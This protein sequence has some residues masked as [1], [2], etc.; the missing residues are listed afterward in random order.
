MRLLDLCRGTLDTGH[1]SIGW[2]WVG[3]LVSAVP[4]WCCAMRMG[5]SRGGYMVRSARCSL[6]CW[7][8]W[9]WE[10]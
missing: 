9:R 3:S 2:D 4:G 1:T 6:L 8:R 10:G 5:L 7:S